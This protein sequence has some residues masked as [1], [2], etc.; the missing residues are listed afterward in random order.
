LTCFIGA[1]APHSRVLMGL[2]QFSGPLKKVCNAVHSRQIARSR[3]AY[4]RYFHRSIAFTDFGDRGFH[5]FLCSESFCRSGHPRCRLKAA[6]ESRACF[7]ATDQRRYGVVR[8]PG[9]CVH[10]CPPS[11]CPIS[12]RSWVSVALRLVSRFKTYCR[13]SSPA[14]FFCERSLSGS[15]TR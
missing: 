5:C 12:S 15:K 2:K 6:S 9:S 4:G 10:R 13:I 1:V 11:R 7:C 8:P 3:T 14:C